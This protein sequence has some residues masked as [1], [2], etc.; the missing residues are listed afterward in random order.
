MTNENYANKRATE[1]KDFLDNKIPKRMQPEY[2]YYYCS[3][4]DSTAL[5]K[6]LK[7]EMIYQ[8]NC[9]DAPKDLSPKA[10]NNRVLRNFEKNLR[11]YNGR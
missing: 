4:G 11:D 1:L 9:S 3:I 7:Q 6:A 10:V 5:E 8:L 2:R